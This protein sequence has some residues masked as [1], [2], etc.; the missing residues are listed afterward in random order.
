MPMKLQ[1]SFI[2]TLALFALLSC[3]GQNKD[4]ED[5][6][7]AAGVHEVRFDASDLS[8]GVYVYRIQVGDS[9]QSRQI[10]VL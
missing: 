7:L 2:A 1:I 4:A 3:K 8:A 9:T 6:R 5:D 10:F